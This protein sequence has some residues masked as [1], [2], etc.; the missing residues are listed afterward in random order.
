MFLFLEAQL[1]LFSL[2]LT[3]LVQR[4]CAIRHSEDKPWQD[5]IFFTLTVVIYPVISMGF[6]IFSLLTGVSLWACVC[7]GRNILWLSGRAGSQEVC[8][9]LCHRFSVPVLAKFSVTSCFSFS[10]CKS[11]FASPLGCEALLI[12]KYCLKSLDGEPSIKYD[13]EIIIVA[14]ERDK[15]VGRLKFYL[16]RLDCCQAKRSVKILHLIQPVSPPMETVSNS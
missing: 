13:I 2:W 11:S 10:L 6:S 14:S 5:C 7:T 9:W 3:K 1:H 12:V 8:F 15:N 16:F 4:T